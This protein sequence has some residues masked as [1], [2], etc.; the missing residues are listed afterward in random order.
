MGDRDLRTSRL[1]V[2]GDVTKGTVCRIC[3]RDV[4]DGRMKYCSDY[5]SNLADAVMWMLNWTP[6]RRRVLERDNKT[7]QECGFKYEWI[8]RGNDHIRAIID[9]KLP[10]R[11]QP[12][13]LDSSFD[14]VTDEDWAEHRERSRQWNEKR[15][16]LKDRY[17]DPNDYDIRLEVDHITPLSEGGH[18]FDPS[19]LQTLC[20]DCHKEKTAREASERA[21]RQTPSSEEINKSLF[22]YVSDDSKQLEVTQK[23]A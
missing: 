7:C 21:D 11:P 4:T 6:V 8:T 22:E 15:D 1:Q 14:E 9:S 5:C 13:H 19:N 23:D 18:P 17:G 2:F 20:T 10:E 3:G 12:P 16:E